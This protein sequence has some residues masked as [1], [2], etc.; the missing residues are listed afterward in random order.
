M[1]EEGVEKMQGSFGNHFHPFI[2][3]VRLLMGCCPTPSDQWEAY[4]WVMPRNRHKIVKKKK[5]ETNHIERF[6]NTLRQR[7]SRLGRKTLS[8]SKK[9]SHHIASIIHFIQHYNSSL[10][11]NVSSS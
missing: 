5:R 10:P 11:L 9:L 3:N 2:A 1:L 7:I 6:N 8:F 4:Q